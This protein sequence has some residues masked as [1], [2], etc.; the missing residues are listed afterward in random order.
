MPDK[1]DE[2]ELSRSEIQAGGHH[3]IGEPGDED[4]RRDAAEVDNE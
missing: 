3:E 2:R 1:P 4:Q